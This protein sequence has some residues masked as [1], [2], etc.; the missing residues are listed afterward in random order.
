MTDYAA[1][2]RTFKRRLIIFQLRRYKMWI[3][4]GNMEEL[5]NDE[6]EVTATEVTDTYPI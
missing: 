6:N 2:I 5:R 3:S 1:K 4:E